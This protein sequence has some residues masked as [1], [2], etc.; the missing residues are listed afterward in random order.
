MYLSD[1]LPKQNYKNHHTMSASLDESALAN[2]M[3]GSGASTLIPL[4]MNASIEFIN[5]ANSINS[6][7]HSKKTLQRV[8]GEY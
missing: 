1:R 7:R 2:I 3:L 4:N 5:N 6:H 8:A